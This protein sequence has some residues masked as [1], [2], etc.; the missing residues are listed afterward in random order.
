MFENTEPSNCSNKQK[1]RKKIN[2]DD[3][4]EANTTNN[5]SS[6]NTYLNTKIK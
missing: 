6:N 1:K 3:A 5:I 2:I 4:T